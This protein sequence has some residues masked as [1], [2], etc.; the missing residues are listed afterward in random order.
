[1]K[2]AASLAVAPLVHLA[3]TL[4]TLEEGGVD[5][6]HFDVEDGSF[7][8]AMNLGTK[9]IQDLRPLTQLPFDVHL[10][11]TNPEWIIPEIA[12]CGANRVSVHAEACAYPRR[13]LGLIDQFHMQAGLAFNPGTTIPPLQFCRPHLAFVLVLSTEPETT[14]CDFLPSVLAKV[15]EG[16]KQE[17]LAGVEWAIDGGITADNVRQVAAAGAEVVVSGRGVFEKDQ[18]RENLRKLRAAIRA[19]RSEQSDVS[20]R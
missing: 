17:G 12:R 8:P 6:L 19:E 15:V 18:I 13:V 1:M 9:I 2:L 20:I 3:A 4:R 10:M 16:K 5:M 7:V 14:H 11:M